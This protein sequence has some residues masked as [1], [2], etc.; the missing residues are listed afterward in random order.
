VARHEGAEWAGEYQLKAPITQLDKSTGLASVLRN[1][2][3]TARFPWLALLVKARLTSDLAHARGAHA[4][5]NSNVELVVAIDVHWS[6]SLGI[7]NRC[8]RG[9]VWEPVIRRHQ[10]APIWLLPEML[11]VV[12]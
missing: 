8:A 3:G 5:N 4:A 9:S 10:D 7:V 12:D 1:V 6:K 2:H 11:I